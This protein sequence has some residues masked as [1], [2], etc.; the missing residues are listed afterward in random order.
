MDTMPLE[1]LL[2]IKGQKLVVI[3]TADTTGPW[4]A[5]VY[6][7]VDDRGVL[8][9]ISG[10]GAKHSQ[11]IVKDSRVA[12]SI[13]WFDANNHKDRKAIQGLGIC[14]PAKDAEEIATG[15]R[16]HNE[17]F[18]EFKERIT[19]DWVHT[20]EWGSKVWVLTP[21]YMKYWNDELYGE[22]ESKEFTF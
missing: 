8:Y 7:G 11:M 19:V 15:V 9:F 18:P 1:P 2:F 21:T 14:R 17:N 4:V 12:F 13:A 10:D 6:Y 5:N 16:L 20:N 22:D 3:A